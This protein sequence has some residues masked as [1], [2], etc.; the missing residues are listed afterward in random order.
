MNRPLP[1]PYFDAIHKPAVIIEQQIWNQIKQRNKKLDANANR[2]CTIRWALNHQTF[3]FPGGCETIDCGK[4][5][6]NHLYHHHNSGRAPKVNW[7]RCCVKGVRRGIRR[8]GGKSALVDPTNSQRN[9]ALDGIAPL[10]GFSG[11]VIAL[12]D[13]SFNSCRGHVQTVLRYVLGKN[14][15]SQ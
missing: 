14:N 10:P 8:S 2:K 11:G 9:E 5:N 4:F 7:I 6:L 15:K 12:I 13:I 1:L 3:R